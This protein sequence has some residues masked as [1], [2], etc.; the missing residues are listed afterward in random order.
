M[1]E[2]GDALG[3]AGRVIHLGGEVRDRGADVNLFRLGCHPGQEH[4]RRRLM[5]V[6]LEEVVLG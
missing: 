6:V 5:R 4:F 2:R 1:I 3:D